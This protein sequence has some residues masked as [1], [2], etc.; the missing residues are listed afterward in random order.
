MYCTVYYLCHHTAECVFS[1]Y[2]IYV[3]SYYYMRPQAE[4][5]P[6]LGGAVEFFLQYLTPAGSLRP[7]TLVACGLIH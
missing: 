2:Y 7:H 3:S 1:Y 4:V 5:L 6:V